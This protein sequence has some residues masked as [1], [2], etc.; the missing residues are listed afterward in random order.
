MV[1]MVYM[2]LR[3]DVGMECQPSLAARVRRDRRHRANRTPTHRT[4]DD[5]MAH[6]GSLSLC[7]CPHG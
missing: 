1:Y 5:R 7:L 4:S 2:V 3:D 6:V